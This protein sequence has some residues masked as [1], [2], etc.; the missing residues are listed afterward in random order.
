MGILSTLMKIGGI[1]AA[2]FTGGASLALTGLG[3]IGDVLGKQQAGAAKGMADTA[4]VTQAQDRNALNLYGTQQDAEFKAGQQDLQRKSYDTTH[5]SSAGKEA[6]IAMLLGSNP[7]AGQVSV[8]GVPNAQ[9]SGGM[10]ETIAKNPQILELLKSIAA[11]AQT[12]QATPSTF[13]GGNL[14][15]PPSLT[16]LPKPGKGSGILDA[17]ARIAQI[18]GAV[19][20]MFTKSGGS[21]SLPTN[22][23]DWGGYG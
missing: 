23:G 19:A 7:S 10:G 21:S 11:K 17:I 6:L 5:R 12:D 20:P 9:I 15:K 8:A 22:G 13:T 18:A 14:V 3:G 16:A 4:A 2:P 1:G